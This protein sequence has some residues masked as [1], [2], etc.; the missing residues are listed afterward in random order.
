MRSLKFNLGIIC[1]EI[2]V[3]RL[4]NGDAMVQSTR[5][6]IPVDFEEVSDEVERC[7]VL[8]RRYKESF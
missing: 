2:S 7:H 1:L 8:P 3:S 4:M 5:K 6:A